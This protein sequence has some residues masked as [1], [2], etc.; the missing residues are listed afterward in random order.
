MFGW[1]GN[2]LRVDLT[3]GTVRREPLDPAFAQKW[4]GCHGF[5]QKVVFDEYDF[6]ERDP[7]SPKNIVVERKPVDMVIERVHRR[8]GQ[9]PGLTHPAAQ[10]F[11]FLPRPGNSICVARHRGPHR[12]AQSF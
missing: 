8:G 5:L 12:R 11:S 10:L 7:M 9:D 2:V 4:Y 3:E 6:R 1:G